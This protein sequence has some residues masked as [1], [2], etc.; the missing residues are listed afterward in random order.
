[1]RKK[2]FDPRVKF[3]L[4]EKLFGP[5]GICFNFAL[6]IQIC[7]SISTL[8]ITSEHSFIGLT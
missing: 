5:C 1:M 7:Y 6:Q 3:V 2:H 4:R 8:V